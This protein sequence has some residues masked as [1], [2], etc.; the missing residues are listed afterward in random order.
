MTMDWAKREKDVESLK[1]DAAAAA[2]LRIDLQGFAVMSL[3]D[4]TIRAFSAGWVAGHTAGQQHV[5]GAAAPTPPAPP[6]SPK[7]DVGGI[8][9]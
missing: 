8:Y 5:P 3:S 6:R 2:L 1:T 7:P 4:D 9:S